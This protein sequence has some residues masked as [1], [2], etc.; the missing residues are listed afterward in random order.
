MLVLVFFK[1]YYDFLGH[2]A[3]DPLNRILGY[4]AYRLWRWQVIAQPSSWI[5][6]SRSSTTYIWPNSQ[7][8]NNDIAMEFH[9]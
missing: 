4:V 7:Q 5:R 3:Q 1:R 2:I 8:I 6:P 9:G